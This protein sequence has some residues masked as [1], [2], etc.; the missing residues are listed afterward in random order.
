MRGE[1]AGPARHVLVAAARLLAP[2]E[3][4]RRGERGRA[5]HPPLLEQAERL[6]PV[7]VELEP[8][9]DRFRDGL[10]QAGHEQPA[11]FRFAHFLITLP[12]AMT[13]RPDFPSDGAIG[14]A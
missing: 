14:D 2:Q 11:N 4:E 7:L 1:F 13:A 8:Q 6:Q 12:A 9:G 3:A 5:N 10:M